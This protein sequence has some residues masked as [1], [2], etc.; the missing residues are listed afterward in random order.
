MNGV[1]D[2]LKDGTRRKILT[3]LKKGPLTAGEIG[4]QFP[5]TASTLSHHLSVLYESGLVTKEKRAQTVIYSLNTTV[6]QELIK[7]VAELFGKEK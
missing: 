3:L 4:E 2:A 7:S 5:V 6:V 1:W